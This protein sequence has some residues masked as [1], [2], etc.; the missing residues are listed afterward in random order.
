MVTVVTIAIFREQAGETVLMQTPSNDRAEALAW[1]AGRLRFEQLLT[2]LQRRA[3][4]NSRPVQLE[5]ADA[6]TPEIRKAA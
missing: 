3:A 4:A 6:G 1:L 5:A 2:D